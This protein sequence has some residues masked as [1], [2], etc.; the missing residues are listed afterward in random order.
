MHIWRFGG[1]PSSQGMLRW[2]L[3]VNRVFSLLVMYDFHNRA[4]VLL[5]LWAVRVV[6]LVCSLACIAFHWM[7]AGFGLDYLLFL[8]QAAFLLVV[9]HTM[10][11]GTSG[12]DNV[13]CP[14]VLLVVIIGTAAFA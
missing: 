8:T 1:R 4:A 5:L 9:G 12:T 2:I 11:E 3:G 13:P 6:K 14:A 7:R 10:L